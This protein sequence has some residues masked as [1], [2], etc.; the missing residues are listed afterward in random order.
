MGYS[1]KDV[2]S[3]GLVCFGVV[4]LCGLNGCGSGFSR[5]ATSPESGSGGASVGTGVAFTGI[6]LGAGKPVAGATVQV[7]A[8]GKTGVR[9]G[10]TALLN[11]ALT[12]DAN[13]AFSVP[14]GYA[15]STSDIQIYAVARGGTRAGSTGNNPALAE[16]VALGPCSSIPSGATYAL[17]EA[18]TVANAWALAPF[19]AA[20]GTVGAT[21]TNVVGLANAVR[22]AQALVD[23]ASGS[24]PGQGFP[25]TASVP[26]AKVNT[27]A[28]LL[29]LCSTDGSSPEC[30]RM[31]AL[32]SPG[33][34]SGRTDTLAAAWSLAHAPATN[35]GTLFSLASTA[36]T[37]SP[38][39][40]SA[41]LDWM[42]ALT[43]RSGGLTPQ[44]EPTTVAID[45]SGNAWVAIY[46]GTVTA[47]SPV[48]VPLFDAGLTGG[49]LD[50]SYGLAIDASGNV[51]V[52]NGAS[53]SAVN[54]GRGTVTELS[55]SGA[56][57]SGLTGYTNSFS[58]GGFSVPVAIAI[59]STGPIW[60]VNTQNSTVTQLNGSGQTISGTSGYG[61][62]AL[63][64]PSPIAIDAAG[65][66]WVGNTYTDTI[67]KI[68][69][70]GKQVQAVPIG[71]TGPQGLAID[72]SGYVWTANYYGNSVSRVQAS[73]AAAVS[74]SPYAGGTLTTPAAIAIDGA[75]SVWVGSFRSNVLSQLAGSTAVVPGA[76]LS[77]VAGWAG[78]AGLNQPFSLA[79]DA[80]G[81]VWISNF[82]AGTV[83]ELIGVATPVGTPLL[84][85]TRQP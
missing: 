46:G 72:A 17:S 55:S 15:C 59:D 69:S 58:S 65:D 66:A 81:D 8:A 44:S 74:G 21:S 11:T 75:G 60:V 37:F 23:S 56:F 18:S 3:A 84:G 54:A 78:D 10:A 13:G 67:V 33:D 19:M 51:W 27:L 57:L 64:F 4:A 45:A 36:A 1:R 82:G 76:A 70:D 28:N 35:V 31:L 47:L 85:P 25:S 38:A 42:L 43:H 68:S 34:G 16:M 61:S 22:M 26:I 9:A 5:S 39:L 50:S 12:T 53:S 73:T 77:P 30:A 41:P 83:T 48:G 62:S 40:S 14:A 63:A 32:A 29:S 24:A 2:L 79:I 80:S 52:G 6:V 49:G 71:S 20:D 7:Y